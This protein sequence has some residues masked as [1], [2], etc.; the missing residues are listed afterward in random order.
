MMKIIAH[1]GA[2]GHAP[3]NTL[4]A[5]KEALKQGVDMVEFDV[6]ALA[7]GEV[8]LMHDH[9]VN[10]TTNGKGYVQKLNFSDL[11]KLNAGDNEIIPTINEV[12]SLINRQLRT[13]IELKGPDSAVA[14][15]DIVK[16]HLRAG[17]QPKDF[18]VSSFNHHE[19]VEFKRL[20]PTVD[21]AVLNDAIPLGY[22]EFAEKL[23]AVAICPSDEFIN[24]PYV[25]DAHRRGMEVYVWTV[26]DPEEVERM[27]V[28]GVDG[29]FTNYPDMARKAAKQFESTARHTGISLKS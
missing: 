9:R 7:S 29:I 24:I 10:R 6:H 27:Y 25:E 14:V 1:R 11:R 17:W 26:N 18:L 3:E 8:I 28:L 21:I 20:V 12:L 15:A 16:R 23:E 5:F 19:L 4:A 2:S 13:N 22:A